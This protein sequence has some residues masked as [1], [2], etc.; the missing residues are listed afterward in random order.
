KSI[1]QLRDKVTA[2]LKLWD[3][4][5][6]GEKTLESMPDDPAAN[7][8]VG[9]WYCLQIGDWKK[10]ISQL[11]KSGDAKLAAAAAAE[12]DAKL[13]EAADAWSTIAEGLSGGEK[14]AVQRHA[15]EIY[16]VASEK[17]TG[18]QQL[19]VAKRVTEMTELLA[20]S[21]SQLPATGGL[22][23]RSKVASDVLRPGLLVRI[24]ASQ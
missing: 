5:K 23:P 22:V 13:L 19:K 20:Q 15:L 24:Y 18:L 1:K 21:E 6:A 3:L 11:A 4:A 14:L 9:K 17:L 10:G 16:Q 7:L 8:A 12:R 2:Q